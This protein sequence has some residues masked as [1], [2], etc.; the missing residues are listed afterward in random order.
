MNVVTNKKKKEHTV[1]TRK[2]HTAACFRVSC[3]FFVVDLSQ[4][5]TIFLFNVVFIAT[6]TRSSHQSTIKTMV[7]FTL[8]PDNANEMPCNI[9]H[10]IVAEGVTEVLNRLRRVF[11]SLETIVFSKSVTIIGRWAFCCCTN[12]KSVIF[13]NDSQLTEIGNSAFH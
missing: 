3:W 4:N 6:L 1:V 12:L 2:R 10:L 9:V 5:F 11:E 7:S 8:T 13:P